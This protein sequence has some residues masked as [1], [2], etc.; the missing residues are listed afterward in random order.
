MRVHRTAVEL[1]EFEYLEDLV[2]KLRNAGVVG[3]VTAAAGEGGS[4]LRSLTLTQR[5]TEKEAKPLAMVYTLC[6]LARRASGI[7]PRV[8]FEC[9]Q[10]AVAKHRRGALHARKV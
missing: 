10:A 4:D 9:A 2:N 5:N 6:E 8:W 3:D 1:A 7:T